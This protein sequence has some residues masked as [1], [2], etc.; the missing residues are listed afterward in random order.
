MK[1]EIIKRIALI[2]VALLV[3]LTFAS[4]GQDAGGGSGSGTAGSSQLA[5]ASAGEPEPEPEPEGPP[6]AGGHIFFGTWDGA[7]IEWRVLEVQDDRALLISEEILTLWQYMD[8]ETLRSWIDAERTGATWARSGLRTWLNG[9][10]LDEAFTEEEVET[11]LLTDVETPGNGVIAGSEPTQDKVFLL[12]REEAVQ[13]FPTDEDRAVWYTKAEEDVQ[14]VV[15]AVVNG[16]IY[17]GAETP[18][19]ELRLEI[20]ERLNTNELGK[21][22]PHYWWLRSSASAMWENSAVVND[23]GEI[24]DQFCCN[25]HGVRP[26]LWVE[27]S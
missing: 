10:F 19:E 8:A 12:S 23:R 25:C 24:S 17:T 11:I 9:E 4:C 15:D 14:K 27:V 21:R 22:Q 26:V 13:Y 5:A 3:A 20:E 16:T 1:M 18:E 7:P 2:A 6:V